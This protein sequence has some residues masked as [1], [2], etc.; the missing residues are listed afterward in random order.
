MNILNH[1]F[2]KK[3]AFLESD[4]RMCIKNLRYI[5]LVQKSLFW[6]FIPRK[7]PE[8]VQ[9]YTKLSAKVLI[10]IA[11]CKNLYSEINRGQYL[12][13]RWYIGY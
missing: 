13:K 2:G 4:L 12:N 5:L 3:T 7:S 1:C 11:N 10:I 9:M 6:T 8:F